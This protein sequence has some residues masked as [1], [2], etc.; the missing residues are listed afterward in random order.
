AGQHR[1]KHGLT[2]ARA[3]ENA[4][5]LSAADRDEGIERAHAKIEGV[6]DAAT[7]MSRR[8]RVAVRIG[9]R[10]RRQRP[11]PVDRLS[12]RIDDAAK[13]AIRGANGAGGRGYHS[14]ATTTYAI[15]G[16]KWHRQGVTT[17][18]ANDLAGDGPRRA[19]LDGQA[20]A[21]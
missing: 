20:R 13:P 16:S 1:Q 17:R 9:R 19:R 15:E 4:H 8:R 7:R 14:A 6:A 21:N 12:P 18:K 2:N 11:L 3:R 10:P 5:A